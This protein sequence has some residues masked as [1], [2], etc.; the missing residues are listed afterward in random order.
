M[1]RFSSFGVNT[2][3]GYFVDKIAMLESVVRSHLVRYPEM[4]IQDTY[5]LIHQA[6]M[7]SG[8]AVSNSEAARLWLEREL[9]EMGEGIPEPL[10]DPI[11]A[12]GEMVRVHLRPFL[13]QGGDPQ[14]LLSA[15]L[16]TAN[17]FR[18]DEA[19]LKREWDIATRM[20]IFPPAE[21]DDFIRSMPGYPAAHH[22]AI[23]TRRYRPAYRVILQKYL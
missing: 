7:G 4:Q 19:T 8:H 22:S 3:H 13:A 21:M 2:V 1:V 10:I 20:E 9:T 12:D 15:F 17:E 18:G 5:K 11:S 23:F 16:H 6:V 14:K